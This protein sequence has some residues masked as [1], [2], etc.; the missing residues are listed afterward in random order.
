ML[1][2]AIN[3]NWPLTFRGPADAGNHSE[4]QYALAQGEPPPNRSS[5]G[6]PMAPI[7]EP[8]PPSLAQRDLAEGR[9][10]GVWSYTMTSIRERYGAD[11][12]RPV[13]RDKSS[14]V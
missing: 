6:D 5:E 10:R 9:W 13:R 3:L 7:R 14:D 1:W 2:L 11:Y 8:Q 12:G 4:R